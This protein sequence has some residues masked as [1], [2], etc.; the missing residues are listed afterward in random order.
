MLLAYS[1]VS[2]PLLALRSPCSSG[3]YGR[4]FTLGR[5]SASVVLCWGGM[6]MLMVSSS[7]LLAVT[8]VCLLRCFCTFSFLCWPPSPYHIPIYYMRCP[9]CTL[10]TISECLK[11]RKQRCPSLGYSRNRVSTSQSLHCNNTS[12]FLYSSVC[13]GEISHPTWNKCVLLPSV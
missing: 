10:D 4:R 7:S 12:G 5:V 11:Y 1:V 2:T 8:F 6:S 9:L 13:K 3:R